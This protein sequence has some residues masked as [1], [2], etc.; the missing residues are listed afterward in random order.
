MEGKKAAYICRARFVL[1]VWMDD[2]CRIRIVLN[3]SARLCGRA[4]E[5]LTK[6]IT[7]TVKVNITSRCGP[8]LRTT[9]KQLL[10]LVLKHSSS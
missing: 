7:P 1:N 5:H 3:A 4:S 9:Q 8:I 6:S 10:L 2:K